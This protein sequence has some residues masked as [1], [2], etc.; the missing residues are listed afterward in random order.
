MN[1]LGTKKLDTKHLI[2]RKM[3]LEDAKMMFKNWTSDERV[4]K[5]LTWLPHQDI[6]DTKKFIQMNLKEYDNPAFYSWI[7]EYKQNG[8]VIGTIGADLHEATRIKTDFYEIGYCMSYNYWHQGIMSEALLCVL[9]F[10]FEEVKAHRVYSCHDI[11]NPAS[12]AVM[13]RC[14]MKEEGISREA[15]ITNKKEYCTLMNYSILD[16]EYFENKKQSN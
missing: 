13:K 11:Y 15:G 3:T 12:G 10:L 16:S 5:Y 2:L 14:G 9:Q 7:M 4:T 6:K 1:H 8:E